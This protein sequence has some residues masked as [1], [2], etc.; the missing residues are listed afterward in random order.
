MS[1]CDENPT[2]ALRRGIS[3]STATYRSS[4]PLWRVQVL[5]DGV[6]TSNRV[7]CCAHIEE[8]S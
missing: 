1:D 5:T 3:E 6:S 2:H 7:R 8:R 4:D